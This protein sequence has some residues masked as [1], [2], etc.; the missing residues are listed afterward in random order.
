MPETVEDLRRAPHLICIARDSEEVLGYLVVDSFVN[1]RSHG[2]V[3]MRQDV[4]PE[5]IGLL[6]R[7][8]TLRYGFLGLPFGGAK[9]GVL[10]NP[11]APPGERRARLARFGGQ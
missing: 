1:G 6:A 2:G 3:R 9:A 10:G 4:T 11:E 7:T 5:E 8:M